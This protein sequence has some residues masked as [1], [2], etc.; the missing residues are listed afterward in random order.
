MSAEKSEKA[1]ELASRS[2]NRIDLGYTLAFFTLTVILV[3]GSAWLCMQD[4]LFKIMMVLAQ[5]SDLLAERYYGELEPEQIFAGAWQGMQSVMPFKTELRDEP[6]A[7]DS[8]T[9]LS[10]WGLTTQRDS[11]GIRIQAITRSSRLAGSLKP[12]DLVV[13]FQRDS[14]KPPEDLEEFLNNHVGDTLSALVDRSGK[15]QELVLYVPPD[16]AREAMT[17]DDFA[18]GIYLDLT[19]LT[20]SSGQSL[21]Q[22]IKQR[23]NENTKRVI[24]DLRGC[25]GISS[26]ESRLDV[27]RLAKEIADQCAGLKRALLIDRH[28]IGDAEKLARELSTGYQF[29][30]VGTRTLGLSGID[31]EIVLRSGK[32]LYVSTAKVVPSAFDGSQGDDSLDSNEDV[33]NEIIP[34]VKCE[35]VRMSPMMFRIIHQG[36]LHDFVVSRQYAEIP[37]VDDE[38]SLFESF[39]SYLEQVGFSFD[40]VRDAAN[41]L[42]FYRSDSRV[43]PLV[44]SIK[45]KAEAEGKVSLDGIRQEVLRYLLVSIYRTWIGGELTLNQRLRLRDNCL[46]QA[47]AVVG[48]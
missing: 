42:N 11:A 19:R 24:I 32:R 17:C 10:D 41:T 18:S 4:S 7:P 39:K 8:S 28:T 15:Q 35:P 2:Q 47:I 44:D 33:G 46:Q 30:T 25:S 16:T 40:P 34:A 5:Q 14:S 31:D 43:R 23:R 12:G 29:T 3:L 26:P 20:A 36:Y 1:T 6:L 27:P 45:R 37:S 38:D 21:M 22:C 9:S 48:E 13:A